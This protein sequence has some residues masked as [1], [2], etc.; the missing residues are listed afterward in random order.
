[1]A[2]VQ[3]AAPG[4]LLVPGSEL[5]DAPEEDEEVPDVLA[6]SL[7]LRPWRRVGKSPEETTACSPRMSGI[8][9][10]RPVR[11]V[12]RNS[13]LCAFAGSMDVSCGSITASIFNTSRKR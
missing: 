4:C 6:P 3:L 13:A 9:L 12:L 2:G 7:V 10:R 5:V 11:P 1:M 8:A